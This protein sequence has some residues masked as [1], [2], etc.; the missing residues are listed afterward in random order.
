MKKRLVIAGLLIAGAGILAAVRNFTTRSD[1]DRM[2]L[3]MGV[4]IENAGDG[5]MS[6]AHE[7]IPQFMPAMTMP[8]VL[9]DLREADR[10]SPGDRVQFTFHVGEERSRADDFKV[11]GRDVRV[12]EAHL[13]ARARSASRLR[14]GDRLPAFALIDQDGAPLSNDD[15]T[16]RSTVITFIFTRCPVPEFCPRIVG[17]FRELQR[18]IASDASLSHARLLA[19]T[20]DPEYDTASVLRQYGAGLGADFG[21]WRFGTGPRPQIAVLTQAF[22]V[23]AESQP[24]GQLDHTLATAVIDKDGRVVEIWRGNV[25]DIQAVLDVLKSAGAAS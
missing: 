17:R 1:S 14:T 24:D 25:W 5:T 20:L 8:F 19:V 21:R 18:A 15:L 4:V 7:P 23:L 11:V 6:I 22:A 2:F 13:A 16:G 9:A 10:L 3:V 12:L